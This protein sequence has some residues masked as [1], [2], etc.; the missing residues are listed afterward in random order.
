MDVI[1]QQ[2][3]EN[4]GTIGDVVKVKPG[5]ARNFL[6]PRGL[7][8]K[9]DAKNLAVLEHRKRAL[10]AKRAKVQKVNQGSGNASRRLGAFHPG[11]CGRGAEAVRL[12]HEPRHPEGPRLAGL[13]SRSQEDPPREPDQD[14]R[15]A[16]RDHRSRRGS[17]SADQGD[18][19][20]GRRADGDRVAV[21]TGARLRTIVARAPDGALRRGVA[22][23]RCR[24]RDRS[25][26]TR[27]GRAEPSRRL[28]RARPRI[29]RPRRGVE[30]R[31]SRSPPSPR[32][33]TWHVAT[34][35]GARASRRRFCR[36][37]ST[38]SNA[39]FHSATTDVDN[40]SPPCPRCSTRIAS[41]LLARFTAT[42]SAL[43][44]IGV[45]ASFRAKNAGPR[46]LIARI[47]GEP[48]GVGGERQRR[49]VRIVGTESSVLVD[50]GDDRLRA[51]RQ[52]G[53]RR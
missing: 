24:A 31:S 40:A 45:C 37:S 38:S 34:S 2:D 15:R 12:G 1:L 7:A 22:A 39:E 42:E 10:V 9:A 41:Q 28:A 3:V 52:S 20:G 30:A 4:L 6:L 50:D 35:A 29:P 44:F 11:T 5:Y 8:L 26:R 43:T 48:H 36:R 53:G 32:S 17:A 16:H 19:R 23:R 14:A 13:R 33:R 27:R 46:I 51:D 49:G 47:S 18:R 21:S 25:G